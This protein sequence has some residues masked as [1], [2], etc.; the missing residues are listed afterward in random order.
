MWI[1]PARRNFKWV[2]IQ[3]TW[4]SCWRGKARL[5]GYIVRCFEKH[6][7]FSQF[8][9]NAGWAF[10]AQAHQ[11]SNT[12]WKL[13]LMLLPSIHLCQYLLSLWAKLK[14]YGGGGVSDIRYQIPD[15]NM[16]W[17]LSIFVYSFMLILFLKCTT[18]NILARSGK[19]DQST[20]K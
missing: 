10:Y 17:S 2:K 5:T 18:V 9:F 7:T 11:W 8:R 16:S 20:H 12:R 15:G 6:E 19:W 4:S 13:W 3:I 1:T 14:T